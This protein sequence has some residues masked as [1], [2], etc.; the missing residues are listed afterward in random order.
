MF[1]VINGILILNIIKI[2]LDDYDKYMYLV[3]NTLDISCKY[4]KFF[5]N[6]SF[7]NENEAFLLKFIHLIL[8]HVHISH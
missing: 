8:F 6:S 1:K 7:E 5:L 3:V 2:F 4:I